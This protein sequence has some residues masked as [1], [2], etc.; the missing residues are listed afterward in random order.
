[1]KDDKNGASILGVDIK[2]VQR[3]ELEI[4]LEFDRICKKH[5]MKYQLYAGTLIGA[6]RHEGFIPWDDDI[7]VCMLRSEYDKF[8]SWV[9]I[10]LNNKYFFQTYKTDLNYINKFAKIRRNG[11]LFV[12]KS[13]KDLE[14]HHGVYIDIFALDN[15]ELKTL[16][17]KWQILVIRVL[18]SFFK[19]RL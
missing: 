3:L 12:E 16:K 11:T 13:V 8:L 15:I 14:I 4:L 1:M 10:E 9:E 5:G 18:D 2:D 17:G 6:I 7:D 19:Y